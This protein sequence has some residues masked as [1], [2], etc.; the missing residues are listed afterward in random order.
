VIGDDAPAHVGMALQGRRDDYA[1]DPR[2]AWP[3]P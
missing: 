3:A 2:F 1:R